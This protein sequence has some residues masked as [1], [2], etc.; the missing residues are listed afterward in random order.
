MQPQSSTLSYADCWQP[1]ERSWALPYNIT[2]VVGGSLLIALA[3]QIAIP[4]AFTPVPITGQTLAVL[5]IGVLL[6]SRKGAATVLLY[7]GEGSLGLPFFA[8]G[9][10]GLAVLKGATAGYLVG[11]VFAAY[12]VGWL[13]ERGWDR[14]LW[15]AAAA[16]MVGNAIIF[17]FG[18]SWLGM[19]VGFP[20][21]F[22]LGL[23]PYLPGMLIKLALASVLLPIGWKFIKAKHQ[24]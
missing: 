18:L 9:A 5:M 7:L 21:A 17:F 8:K 19:F 15:R 6:G 13:A 23:V 12:A 20:K 3:A 4:L 14:N 22:T 1:T 2:L 16:M 10:G 24:S 11:F